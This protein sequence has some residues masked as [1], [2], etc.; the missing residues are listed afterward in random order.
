MLL[1]VLCD[2]GPTQGVGHLMRCLALAEE[3]ALR[4]QEV[5]FVADAECVPFAAAQLAERDF[6]VVPPP[7]GTSGYATLL[8]QLG[9]DLVVIDS[10]LLPLEV[11]D[12]VA[13]R[14]PT[15]ALV[16][17]DPEGRRAHLYVD[18]NIGAEQDTWPLPE[19]AT[20]LAGLG[21]ALQRDEVLGLR[22]EEP[23]QQEHRPVRV[24]AFF[25][26]TDAFGAGP[27]VTECLVR[28]GEPF[29]LT[30]V[31][32][33]PWGPPVAGEGQRVTLTGPTDRLAAHV[34]AADVVVSAAGSSSWEL[35]CLRAACG[36]VCVADNQVTSYQRV[37]ETGTVHGIGVLDEIRADDAGAV[38]RLRQLLVDADLR[39]RLR[40]A[41]GEAV[42]GEGRRRVAD[43][44]LALVGS[45]PAPGLD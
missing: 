2:L 17:G 24:F 30:V 1:A 19:G 23:R 21:Y 4:G 25:G 16:D 7:A 14:W 10:Y 34:V 45:L 15:V 26:G 22:P 5:V 28:T 9:P 38:G 43:A 20:R 18:Q 3:L 44:A 35:L 11:Y 6:R 13:A 42:D 12:A 27:V 31:A 41:A 8:E 32:P 36:L 29:D 40:A 33:T 37:V 39:A